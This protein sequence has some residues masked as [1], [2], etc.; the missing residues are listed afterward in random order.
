MEEWFASAAAV[1][2]GEPFTPDGYSGRWGLSAV[3]RF[4]VLLGED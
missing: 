2:N 1:F 3:E 4:R